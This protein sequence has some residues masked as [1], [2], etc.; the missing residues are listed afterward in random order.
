MSVPPSCASSDLLFLAQSA[1]VV[2]HSWIGQP[3][4]FWM[5]NL[6][7]FYLGI[8]LYSWQ[9]TVLTIAEIVILLYVICCVFAAL[10][11]PSP[12]SSCIMLYLNL[13]LFTCHW[14]V[15]DTAFLKCKTFP[16]ICLTCRFTWL[17]HWIEKESGEPEQSFRFIC[18]ITIGTSAQWYSSW[19]LI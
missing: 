13:V 4:S 6:S 8:F 15:V 1:T 9:L 3:T 12:R 18:F 19:Y 10:W 2:P 11:Y 16:A 7:P 17:I 5:L 14:F